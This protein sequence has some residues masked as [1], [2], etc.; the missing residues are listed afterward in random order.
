MKKRQLEILGIYLVTLLMGVGIYWAFLRGGKD[1]FVFYEA[2]ELVLR[3][4][5]MEMYSAT[6]TDRFLYAPGF[7][8]L[9]V[10]FA[11]FSKSFALLLWSLMKAGVFM[12]LIKKISEKV[13][14]VAAIFGVFM[15]A[16]PLL[17]DFQYGQIN[18][19][20]FAVCCL[21][22]F[23]HF[24]KETSPRA[25]FIRWTGLAFL[26]WTKVFALPLLLTPFLKIRSE[27]KSIEQAGVF[28]G[29]LLALLLPTLVFG[30]ENGVQI[31][32]A[33]FDALR[34][35]GLPLD[36]H[37]QS[38][39]A[40]LQHLFTHEPVHVIAQGPQSVVLGLGW[41]SAAAVK[42]LAW[43]WMF[44]TSLVLL[45]WVVRGLDHKKKQGFPFYWVSILTAGLIVPSYLVW[46]PYFV[47]GY[48]VAAY[49]IDQV[50]KRKN[51]LMSIIFL[52]FIFM[53][54]NFTGFDFVGH[55]WGTRFETGSVLLFMHLLLMSYCYK[56]SQTER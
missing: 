48:L 44:A 26:A 2:A 46:K 6:Q 18:V 47:F 8:V 30:L 40:F 37:N 55:T 1:F 23:S 3:G 12:A 21:A 11:F 35:K 54:I 36:S 51:P 38:F 14:S 42:S 32:L 13:S 41:M 15:I 7:A 22:L 16:R 29:L 31:H 25:D 39:F 24:E 33:W 56:L 43:I 27:K 53:G 49:S 9:M 17:I 52:F 28:F 20:I 34:S 10:P 4:H 45:Y 5:G 50:M 19:L